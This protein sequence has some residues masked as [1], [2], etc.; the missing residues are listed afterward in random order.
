MARRRD[1]A[2]PRRR[3]AATRSTMGRR[4]NPFPRDI[5]V[6]AAMYADPAF[7]A[8]APDA[9]V[10]ALT[11]RV[12]KNPVVVAKTGRTYEKA[13]IEAWIA[14][15]HT[16]PCDRRVTLE[17]FASTCSSNTGL[18]AL[19]ERFVDA[20]KRLKPGALL[21]GTVA[22][23]MKAAALKTTV[24]VVEHNVHVF[25]KQPSMLR[26]LSKTLSFGLAGDGR[27]PALGT[28]PD[29]KPNGSTVD[30][31]L[32]K[33]D[34][35]DV[36]VF[37]DEV[38][39]RKYVHV[40]SLEYPDK[41]KP[42]DGR[43]FR[44]DMDE[45][46]RVIGHEWANKD[47]KAYKTENFSVKSGK[48][49]TF[50][51]Y[52]QEKRSAIVVF[53]GP[54]GMGV[55][56]YHPVESAQPGDWLVGEPIE[57][58]AYRGLPKGVRFMDPSKFDSIKF[59]EDYSKD[60]DAHFMTGGV[61][62]EPI[63]RIFP[64]QSGIYPKEQNYRG[65]KRT[66]WLMFEIKLKHPTGSDPEL[67]NGRPYTPIGVFIDNRTLLQAGGCCQ[68][69]N[70]RDNEGINSQGEGQPSFRSGL[71]TDDKNKQHFGALLLHRD[72]KYEPITHFKFNV[73][74]P[75]KG[76]PG[77]PCYS[78]KYGGGVHVGLLEGDPDLLGVGW[79]SN[80]WPTKD[81]GNRGEECV[82]DASKWGDKSISG[83]NAQERDEFYV[84]N[85]HKKP[86]PPKERTYKTASGEKKVVKL[87]P[88]AF[89]FPRQ[90]RKL[91]DPHLD[92]VSIDYP[93][94][95]MPGK[96]EPEPKGKWFR[97]KS[98]Q[99]SAITGIEDWGD[100]SYEG[101]KTGVI[102][103]GDGASFAIPNDTSAGERRGSVIVFQHESGIGVGC[104]NPCDYAHEGDWKPGDRIELL[105]YSQD[106]QPPPYTFT[107]SMDSYVCQ[108]ETGWNLPGHLIRYGQC[109]L[110]GPWWKELEIEFQIEAASVGTRIYGVHTDAS[111]EAL[112]FTAKALRSD[113]KWH[114]IELST[115][116][117]RWG[118]AF[119]S[120][121]DDVSAVRVRWE[122]TDLH[123]LANSTA[124][125]G[126]GIHANIL[127]TS[128]AINVLDIRR[129]GYP[130]DGSIFRFDKDAVRA[131]NCGKCD[132]SNWAGTYEVL[133]LRN[134]KKGKVMLADK[135]DETVLETY[136][137]SHTQKPSEPVPADKPSPVAAAVMPMPPATTQAVMPMASH[138]PVQKTPYRN[139]TG[140]LSCCLSAP[141]RL[142]TPVSNAE[143][144]ATATTMI[145]Y[146]PVYTEESSPEKPK[147]INPKQIVQDSTSL[148]VLGLGYWVED[149]STPA[150]SP[151]DWQIG[152]IIMISRQRLDVNASTPSV[153]EDGDAGIAA[154]ERT[155]STAA[156]GD[157]ANIRFVSSD[158]I[159]DIALPQ[160]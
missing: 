66:M 16:E 5:D 136:V 11:L 127:G 62:D 15:N 50:C 92:V 19:V 104:A 101:W 120:I 98:S 137:A 91:V 144:D 148:D 140:F 51:V 75:D 71:C 25:K 53:G 80:K 108:T 106:N 118:R 96:T 35:G 138:A 55:G 153:L 100:A 85:P 46:T 132:G 112:P 48:G 2:T 28:I 33:V 61:N 63:E 17:D 152:D 94:G 88:D 87:K 43:F 150:P 89:V 26:Q 52:R 146:K 45:L 141:K 68:T 134:G 47:L 20:A 23:R 131:L 77:V 42:A 110:V 99:L 130:S 81:E 109:G 8:A 60:D 105:A 12:M 119:K 83:P 44:F 128:T 39:D 74:V 160:I 27:A 149:V 64:G 115:E 143:S 107:L 14:I 82:D 34:E 73:R 90:R 58:I 113:G 129:H 157:W 159:A 154:L 7:H 4:A 41:S 69:Y 29:V 135:P 57:L 36:V 37:P 102:K 1:A 18:Y 155:K 156:A 10:C 6:D 114:K 78:E 38:P 151:G 56:C 76:A 3:D 22:A 24:V 67:I 133:N 54:N 49:A 142:E 13:A 116:N 145:V 97:F 147:P 72:R 31:G 125:S 9:Y 59:V 126:G 93:G 158:D 111:F 121:M 79:G 65:G 123:K 21:D 30:Q 40:T 32:S 117:V 103:G 124:R 95:V 86:P 139:P 70:C 84:Y 122:S